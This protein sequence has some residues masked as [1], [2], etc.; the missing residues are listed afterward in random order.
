MPRRTIPANFVINICEAAYNGSFLIFDL[1]FT[2]VSRPAG[3]SRT[4]YD[5]ARLPL[6]SGFI[7]VLTASSQ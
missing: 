2:I 3:P 5:T 6:L 1:I 4:Y 7:R